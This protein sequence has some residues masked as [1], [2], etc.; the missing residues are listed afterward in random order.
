MAITLSEAQKMLDAALTSASA[1]GVKGSICVVD[2][3]GIPLAL[4]RMD[5]ARFFTA[6]VAHGKAMVS[7]F[8]GQPSAALA[9]RAS[10]PFFSSFNQMNGG[11][12]FF[13]QGAV[14]VTQNEELVGAIGVSGG[15]A[16]QDEDIAKAGLEAL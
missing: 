10:T 15:S 2:T 5:G 8:F 1:I 7:A 13:V 14:P 4:A 12:L 6:D 9:E 3:Q 11:R 16:Q